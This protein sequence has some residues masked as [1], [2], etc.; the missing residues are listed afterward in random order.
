M[1]AVLSPSAATD[2]LVAL[3]QKQQAAWGSGDYSVVGTTLQIVGE[4]LCE[5]ADVQSGEDVLDARPASH[6]PASSRGATRTWLDGASRPFAT[7][8]GRGG[9]IAKSANMSWCPA[10]G[11]ASN[12][13]PVASIH[14]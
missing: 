5:A 9:I 14:L 6:G 7:A 12:S 8:G 2:P 4:T 10:G 11:H 1:N 3:K 13:G